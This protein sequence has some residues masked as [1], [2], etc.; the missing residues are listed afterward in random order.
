MRY[1]NFENEPPP[2]I[3]NAQM[4]RPNLGMQ[5]PEFGFGNQ[6]G[7]QG[8]LQPLRGYISQQLQQKTNEEIGPF[9]E[10]VAGNAQ[11][12][13][14]IEPGGGYNKMLHGGLQPMWDLSRQ[15]GG[16]LQSLFQP[17][18]NTAVVNENNYNRAVPMAQG[19][20]VPRQ[21]MIEEQP[22]MLAYIDPQEEMMLRSMGG[23]GQPGPG[24][25][26][27]YAREDGP[28]SENFGSEAK[29]FQ[30]RQEEEQRQN[31][32]DDR[33]AMA[34][35][36]EKFK[37]QTL[38][39]KLNAPNAPVP[40][41]TGTQRQIDAR[42]EAR[43]KTGIQ[44]LIMDGYVQDGDGF[45]RD[46]TVLSPK[47]NKAYMINQAK[48]YYA[49]PYKRP[50]AGFFSNLIKGSMP[51]QIFS[52]IFNQSGI[53]N[54]KLQQQGNYSAD[55]GFGIGSF[56]NKITN[57]SPV[58]QVAIRDQMGKVIGVVGFNEKGTPVS[59][60]GKLSGYMDAYESEGKGT[61]SQGQLVDFGQ[62]NAFGLALGPN[63]GT[64]DDGSDDTPVSPT[65]PVTCPDG[66]IFDSETNACVAVEETVEETTEEEPIVVDPNVSVPTEYPLFNQ[67][68][69]ASLNDVARNMSRG[70]RG[71]AGY[72]GFM[73]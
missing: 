58:N 60:T 13:F 25:V 38:Q 45:T 19:G 53:M 17:A 65:S 2:M 51:G 4:I 63:S 1:K 28:G 46:N 72:Q 27:V 49:D 7:I 26:P 32:A 61:I 34:A 21:T 31:D 73:R 64:A 22:H 62:D 41:A 9:I 18:Q 42:R 24:G 44:N 48:R 43:R 3:Q 20:S 37:E 11:E 8:A 23:T 57:T 47:D 5:L 40:D 10:E 35:R 54:D 69:V 6:G 36:L 12:T 14:D 70:P 50:K 55:G 67:G 30:D 15:Q 71:I 29:Q 33:A 59:H 39:G 16:G 66:Y 68:G 52:G 56:L